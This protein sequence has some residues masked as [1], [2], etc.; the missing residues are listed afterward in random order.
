MSRVLFYKLVAI[1]VLSR[2][3]IF[4]LRV[5]IRGIGRCSSVLKTLALLGD[6]KVLAQISHLYTQGK[7]LLLDTNRKKQ[8]VL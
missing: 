5:E 2:S 6:P 3:T 1:I 8:E 4:F 7:D